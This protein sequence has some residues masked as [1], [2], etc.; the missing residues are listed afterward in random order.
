[1]HIGFSWEIPPTY[2]HP[3]FKKTMGIPSLKINI[4]G[5]QNT[6]KYV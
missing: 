1:M 2:Y 4:F 6:K 5:Y 3:C